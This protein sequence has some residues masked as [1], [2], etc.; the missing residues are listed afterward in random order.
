MKHVVLI[1][2]L[3]I[4]SIFLH[5][6]LGYGVKVGAGIASLHTTMG[7]NQ[8]FTPTPAWYGGIY[9]TYTINPSFSVQ[10]TLAFSS[11]GY[12]DYVRD[13]AI[14][15]NDYFRVHSIE[16]IP[17]Q[18]FYTPGLKRGKILV[19]AGPVLSYG[20]QGRWRQKSFISSIPNSS[21]KLVFVNDLKDAPNDITVGVYGKKFEFG[22]ILSLGYQF[23]KRV[24]V[25]VNG[26]G[27][28][29]NIAPKSNGKKPTYTDRNLTAYASLL[30]QI[31]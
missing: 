22:G 31:R 30:Y 2:V 3:W 8:F 28:L 27:S 11:K 23:K 7:E 12:R 24:S 4:C 18:F 26:T 20:L 10:S 17:L 15:Y 16:L 13:G 5:A 6:Q 19:G 14:K 29:Q 9:D 21:G 1:L 25:L